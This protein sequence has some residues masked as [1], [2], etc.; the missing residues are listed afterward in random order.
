MTNE[1]QTRIKRQMAEGHLSPE[2]V[3]KLAEGATVKFS[4]I[5]PSDLEN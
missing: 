3:G 4:G 5:E 1:E 2:D